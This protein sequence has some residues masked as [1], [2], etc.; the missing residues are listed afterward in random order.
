MFILL[1]AACL[2]VHVHA[3]WGGNQVPLEGA[4]TPLS[5]TEQFRML[6]ARA[7]RLFEAGQTDNAL[8]YANGAHKL[9]ESSPLAGSRDTVF[10]MNRLG[11]LYFYTGYNRQAK[12][13]YTSSLALAEKILPQGDILFG[14][15]H[16]NLGQVESRLNNY[17]QARLHLES[18]LAFGK[19]SKDVGP[20]DLAITMDNL[21]GIYG[22]MGDLDRAENLHKEAL[23]V[24]LREKGPLND[25]VA[26]TLGNLGSLYIMMRDYERAEAYLLRAY[27]THHQ[28]W[29]PSDASTLLD[30]GKLAELY[31]QTGNEPRAE[32]IVNRLVSVG[33]NQL[34]RRHM[35]LAHYIYNLGEFAF[36]NFQLG[37]AERLTARA[38]QLFEAAAGLF[39][40]ETLDAVHLLADILAAKGNFPAAEQKYIQLLKAYGTRDR[41]KAAK[42]K[43]GLG[44][45][46][47]SRGKPSYSAAIEMFESA[48][49]DL[50]TLTP[51]EE[52]QLASALGNLGQLYSDDDRS[53]LAEDKYAEAL[54]LLEHKEVSQKRPWLLHNQ[55]ILWYHLGKYQKSRKGYEEAKRIWTAMHS[56][57][58]PFVATTAANLALVYWIL[59]ENDKA[60]M[61]FTEANTIRDRE[62][63]R[64]LTIGTEWER[65]TYAR[66][67]QDDLY[68]VTSFCFANPPCQ[69]ES[70]N[71]V[72]TMV[73]Q[74][75]GRVLDAMAQTMTQIRENLK[76]ED[77]ILL[78]RLNSV[79]SQIS[80][81]FGPTHISRDLSRDQAKL[82]MLKA[83]EESLLSALSHKSALYRARLAPVQVEMVKRELPPNAAL[84]E[85]LRYPVF[86]PVRTGKGKPWRDARY[87]ALVLQS[88]L[89]PQL[90]DL[91]PAEKIET[92][93]DAFRDKLR[94]PKRDA[95]GVVVLD[96]RSGEGIN[97]EATQLHRLLIDPLSEMLTGSRLV[98]VAPD[99]SLNLVPF[100]LLT[101]ENDKRLADRFIV[102]LLYSGRDMLR[103]K[104]TA[105]STQQVVVIANPD[106]GAE[107]VAK[108]RPIT[109][110]FTRSGN[111]SPLPG[112]RG[113]ARAIQALFS[114]VTPI[115]GRDATVDAMKGV[116]RPVILHVATHGVFT[117]MESAEP[118]WTKDL[119]AVG[120]SSYMLNRAVPSAVENPML[121]AGLVMAG[122]NHINQGGQQGIISALEI[123]GLDLRGTQLAVLSACET[124]VGISKQ[125]DE[126]AGLRRAL[127]I[128]GAASQV[129]SLWK[130]DDA[131][132]SE[133]MAIY[134]RQ[135]LDG[136]GRA[137]ALQLAQQRIEKRPGWEHPYFWAAFI[138]SGDWRPIEKLL[139]K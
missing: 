3:G 50:R 92:A 112:T 133:L 32:E 79:Q 97:H 84:I 122:A 10:A 25:H 135:L 47:R 49:E 19:K 76:G 96:T 45:M 113:E 20:G 69:G 77:R 53:Q 139:P 100:G 99:G 117:P 123:A 13:W 126:F 105:S 27:K 65:L 60:L 116:E 26:T 34:S 75:K 11:M 81:L 131:A 125:G 39:A 137:E 44:K 54:A 63:Q 71:L 134:Y 106:F 121:Y 136:R 130:V 111:F 22:A 85:Y 110:R 41:A 101:N 52:E 74:R 78:N 1:L 104:E 132:T 128:A 14:N 118:T 58:H 57:D 73:L 86:D 127:S 18:A 30:L 23:G 38:V 107:V 4:K 72:A 103:V 36:K 59:G 80:E 40:P 5:P 6:V 114:Q 29:G 16:N 93:T 46:L 129:T 21:A 102:N 15:L 109:G 108:S 119:I 35:Q 66:G 43:I 7:H 8:T 89:E 95:R 68:K 64:T 28:L 2:F 48:V 9:G 83:E 120:D 42:A 12:I 24:F 17:H 70:A 56:P 87:A 91:G 62:A 61:S 124:G 115:E 94:T 55:A 88:G 37:L 90:F 51:V 98:L 67:M 33:G 138:P 31:I 82:A